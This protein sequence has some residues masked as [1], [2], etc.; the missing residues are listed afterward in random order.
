KSLIPSL[1]ISYMVLPKEL[2]S[3]YKKELSFYQ[4]TV[5]RIDQHILTEF[6]KQGDFERH[7]NRM[8]KIYRRKLDKTLEI[9]KPYENIKVIGEQSGLHIVLEVRNG[10]TENQLVQQAAKARIQIYPLSSYSLEKRNFE[11]SMII[12]GFAG[13]PED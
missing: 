12:L 8:R 4:C 1:R 11:H 6:M 5:S 2:L 3:K 9:L 7:L 10:M 13:I